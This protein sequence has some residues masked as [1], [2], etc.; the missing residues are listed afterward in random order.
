MGIL[1]KY[2]RPLKWVFQ[3]VKEYKF[4]IILMLLFDLAISGAS[5]YTV[6]LSKR[7]IDNAS[8]SLGITG[9]IILY[10]VF[11]LGIQIVSAAGSLLSTL[12]NEKVSFGIRKDVYDKIIRASWHTV[13]RYHSGDIVTRL[14]SDAGNVADG[15]INTI[16]SILQL[17]IELILVFFTLFYYSHFLAIL[18]LIVAPVS[19]GVSWLFA[20]R[21]KV[22]QKKVQE[23]ESAYHSFLQESLANL[24]IVKA[25]TNEDY[26]VDKLTELRKERFKWVFRRSKFGLLGTTTI[27]LAFQIGYLS[28]FTY[29]AFLISSKSITYGT[30]SVFLAL[31]NRVQ[32]PIVNLAHQIP[33][34]VSLFTSAERIMEL[35]E[36]PP[37]EKLEVNIDTTLLGVKAEH[38]TFAYDKDTVLEDVSFNIAPGESTAVMGESGIGKTTLIRLVM[39]FVKPTEGSISYY[40]TKGEETPGSAG[41]RKYT[42]YVPQGN[43][44]FSGTIR[45]NILAGKHDATDAEIEE[46]LKLASAYDFISELSNGVDTVI[47]EKGFGISEGQAQRIAIARAF[48][49][50]APFLIFDEATSALDEATEQKVIGGLERLTPRPSC[51]IITHRKSI[52]KFCTSQIMIE[53]KKITTKSLN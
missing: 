5:L 46:A 43:T 11:M 28:A 25:F 44:L 45:E 10:I 18:A 50:K 31:V 17:C 37:E 47:G 1:K 35:S 36:I 24:L 14:T 13:N 22:L 19:V 32:A 29:G 7:I 38:L 49:K 34:I 41:I 53:D 52:L 33:K 4:R 27:G 20:R 30:M 40:N 51:L 39:S 16:P 42:A 21:L 26:S 15:V 12:V 8:E 9:I 2:R 23:S 48:I 6:I 3:Y